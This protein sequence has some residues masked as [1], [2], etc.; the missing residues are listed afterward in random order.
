VAKSS[1]DTG[2]AYLPPEVVAKIGSSVA[3]G[4]LSSPFVATGRS[5]VKHVFTFGISD[6]NKTSVACDIVVG[7]APADETKVLSLFIKIYDVGAK[8]AVLC[9]IPSLTQEAKKLSGMYKMV[10]V[11]APDI[12]GAISALTEAVR[13]LAAG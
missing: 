1:T 13:R 8:H 6:A 4:T 5:G 10:V 11:E 7:K 3:P 9:V 2:E 12:E